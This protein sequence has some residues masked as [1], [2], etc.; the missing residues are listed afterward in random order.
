M[1]KRK[2]LDSLIILALLSVSAV[3]SFQVFASLFVQGYQN[4]SCYYYLALIWFVFPPLVHY[5]LK[6]Y[7]R[8]ALNFSNLSVILFIALILF[9]E[10]Y[11]DITF[12]THFLGFVC[13]LTLIN[14]FLG[15]ITR[16]SSRE[17]V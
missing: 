14:F 15:I 10:N 5:L 16:K 7:G 11:E 12:H 13:V 2:I 8:L 3:S 1:N 9:P 17:A 4:L 6:L